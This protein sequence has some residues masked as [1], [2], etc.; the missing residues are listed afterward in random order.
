MCLLQVRQMW[1]ALLFAQPDI[2]ESDAGAAAFETM[3][4]VFEASCTSRPVP[5]ELSSR[6]AAES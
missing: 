4:R 3:V 6:L 2:R 5:D 1:E